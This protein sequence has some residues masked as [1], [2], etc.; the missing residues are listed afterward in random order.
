MA[1]GHIFRVA[2]TL[3]KCCEIE[4]CVLFLHGRR[5]LTWLAPVQRGIVY[6]KRASEII[7]NCEGSKGKADEARNEW[8]CH[9]S[10]YG[11]WGA[12]LKLQKKSKLE[13]TQHG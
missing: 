5:Q 4:S 8:S 12:L 7:A 10:P 3:M 13:D 6:A 2:A 11:T 1:K 9:R